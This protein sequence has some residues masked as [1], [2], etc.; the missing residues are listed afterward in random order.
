MF[1]V[2]IRPDGPTVTTSQPELAGIINDSIREAFID[3]SS[4]LIMSLN[5]L[6]ANCV[7]VTT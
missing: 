2:A 4:P 7:K 6:I 5:Q 1:P 3:Q